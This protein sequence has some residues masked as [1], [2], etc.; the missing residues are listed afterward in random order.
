MLFLWWLWPVLHSLQLPLQLLVLLHLSR[1]SCIPSNCSANLPIKGTW[2]TKLLKLGSSVLT[3]LY[4]L[5]WLIP[6]N[7]VILLALWYKM[8]QLCGFVPEVLTSM[9]YNGLALRS[10]FTIISGLLIFYIMPK[11]SSLLS[12]R[13]VALLTG[14]I[15]TFKYVCSKILSISDNKMLDHVIRSL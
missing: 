7:R 6:A 14:Y 8:Q 3:T 9:Q 1:L 2:I 12:S 15:A 13:L 10:G 5:A 4:W 11:M